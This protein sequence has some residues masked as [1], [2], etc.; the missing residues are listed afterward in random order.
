M[1]IRAKTT[2]AMFW[3][4]AQNYSEQLISLVVFII[5]AREFLDSHDF[6]LVVLATFYTAFAKLFVDVGTGTTVIQRRDVPENYLHTAFWLQV[7]LGVTVSILVFA[8]SGPLASISVPSDARPNDEF[9]LRWIIR[10]LSFTFLLN[11][12]ASI[13]NALLQR[14]LRFRILAIRNMTVSVLWA[15]VGLT[16]A[17]MGAGVWTLVIMQMFK[18]VASGLSIWFISGYTPRMVFDRGYLREHLSFS[19]SLAG[20]S[21]VMFLNGRVQDFLIGSFYGAAA[22]GFFDNGMRFYR[23]IS[24]ALFKSLQAILLP[25]FSRVQDDRKRMLRMMM[26][27]ERMKM[28]V[29]LPLFLGM[30]LLSKEIVLFTLTD[31]FLASAPVMTWIGYHG[32][33]K[34]FLNFQRVVVACGKPHWLMA[35]NVFNAVTTIV[36]LVG[37]SFLIEDSLTYIYA[38]AAVWTIR[39]YIQTPFRI[40]L[41]KKLIGFTWADAWEIVWRPAAASAFMA[42]VV[43][44]LQQLMPGDAR[45]W[46]VLAVCVPAGALAYLAA[47]VPLAGDI[48]LELVGM[49]R[50]IVVRKPRGSIVQETGV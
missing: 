16:S 17:L 14:N 20:S 38:V 34:S 21:I 33:N 18:S 13:H 31:K 42:G 7:G 28:V 11:A 49:V 4:S 48:V 15:V 27:I 10:A 36:I 45:P 25:V 3:Q 2:R 9:T 23:Q 32:I 39:G 6:G 1:T 50:E 26:K 30:S 8:L 44:L 5:L 46:Q 24:E 37:L 12:A 29:C 22:L 19:S 41:L 35:I 47:I 43:V 40:H